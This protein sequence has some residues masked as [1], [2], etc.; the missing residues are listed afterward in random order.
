MACSPCWGVFPSARFRHS[1]QRGIPRRQ[2]DQVNSGGSPTRQKVFPVSHRGFRTAIEWGPPCV[3]YPIIFQ[4]GEFSCAYPTP[5]LSSSPVERVSFQFIDLQIKRKH[6]RLLGVH[7][8]EP[9]D[10]QLD[11]GLVAPR[12]G[13]GREAGASLRNG[14]CILWMTRM[15]TLWWSEGWT[16]AETML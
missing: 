3:S 4:M 2:R 8:K 13:Q 9:P 15:E 12:P 5:G 7:A 10:F 6:L 11:T 16:V 1:E 14:E